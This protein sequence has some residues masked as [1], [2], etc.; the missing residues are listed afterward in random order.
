MSPDRREPDPD[1]LLNHPAIQDAVK[2]GDIRR[3][4]RLIAEIAREQR[5]RRN[6]SAP[7]SK[8][9]NGA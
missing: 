3:L 2:K 4:N 1:S 6:G 5:V 8:R 7:V 9:I